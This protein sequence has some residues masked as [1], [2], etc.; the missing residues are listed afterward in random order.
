MPSVD[1]PTAAIAAVPWLSKLPSAVARELATRGRIVRRRAGEWLY[2]E[3]DTELG[4]VAV[5]SGGLYMYTQIAGG[6]EALLGALRPG[7]IVGQTQLVGGEKRMLTVVASADSTFLLLPDHLLKDVA[8]RHPEVW[9]A[10]LALTFA[11]MRRLLRLTTEAITFKPRERLVSR[12]LDLTGRQSTVALSQT[13]LAEMVGATRKAVNGW[14]GELE[15]GG[16]VRRGY[17]SVEVLD[18]A[19]LERMLES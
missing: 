9:E 16:K 12:L 7:M 18:R 10:F 8:S 5:I 1:T 4:L 13:A 11:Q 19:A 3:G 17:G 14:L 6:R 15:R 2:A